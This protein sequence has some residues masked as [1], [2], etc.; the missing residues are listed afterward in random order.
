MHDRMEVTLLRPR[1]RPLGL[2]RGCGYFLLQPAETHA[3]LCTITIFGLIS[4][5]FSRPAA[6]RHS[7][8][9]YREPDEAV[10]AVAPP[11]GS[12]RHPHVAV[13]LW[14]LIYVGGSL[15]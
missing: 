14:L 10:C 9:P 6:A 7:Q 5:M 13:N 8:A 4:C 2:T 1:R 11:R 3:E 12:Y 15:F